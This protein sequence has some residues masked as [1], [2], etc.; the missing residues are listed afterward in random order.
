MNEIQSIEKFYQKIKTKEIKNKIKIFNLEKDSLTE[1]ELINSLK[2]NLLYTIPNTGGFKITILALVTHIYQEGAQFFRARKLEKNFNVNAFEL[3]DFWE[4][5]THVVGLGRF[6]RPLEPY[7]YL[8]S[9]EYFTPKKEIGIKKGERYLLMYYTLNKV[10]PLLSFTQSDTI[11]KLSRQTRKKLKLILSFINDL[12]SSNNDNAHFISSALST[13]ILNFNELDGWCYQS[14]KD[15][16]AINACVK[17]SKKEKFNLKHTFLCE[18]D[19][20]GNDKFI[21][22]F[23]ILDDDV[24]YSSFDINPTKVEEAVNNLYQDNKKISKMKFILSKHNK[25][26]PIVLP[27]ILK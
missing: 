2:N 21:G 5:P 1:E 22:V 8:T 25:T 14:I 3:K 24:S 4:P 27:K 13:E 11:S 6:N 20:D 15:N 10:L 23:S 19:E 18:L 16:N 17:V 9:G 26:L 7:L 12:M